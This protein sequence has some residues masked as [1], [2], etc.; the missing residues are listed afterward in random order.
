[1]HQVGAITCTNIEPIDPLSPQ[2]FCN[3]L[4]FNDKKVGP[5]FA[6]SEPEAMYFLI[7]FKQEPK[8]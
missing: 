4:T 7:Q 3:L 8:K 6:L 1:M 2:L 5:L